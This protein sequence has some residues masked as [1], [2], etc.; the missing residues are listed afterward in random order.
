MGKKDA[1]SIF[2]HLLHS[3]EQ[4]L[5][6]FYQNGPGHSPISTAAP[7]LDSNRGGRGDTPD[8]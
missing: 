8:L 4:L 2:P 7:N 3:N 6:N 1:Q 5:H